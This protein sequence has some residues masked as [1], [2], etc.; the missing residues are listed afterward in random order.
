M[1]LI[2]V[3]DCLLELDFRILIYLPNKDGKFTWDTG[4]LRAPVP[5]SR[6]LFVAV[7]FCEVTASVITDQ[8]KAQPMD[9][10]CYLIKTYN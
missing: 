5:V 10:M 3:I 4:Y 2:V 7:E 6:F 9:V 1:S 8:A